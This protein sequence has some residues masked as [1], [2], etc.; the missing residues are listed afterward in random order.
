[1]WQ[2][3][4]SSEGQADGSNQRAPRRGERETDAV[5]GTMVRAASLPDAVSWCQQVPS[6]Y[7]PLDLGIL[8]E[9]FHDDRRGLMLSLFEQIT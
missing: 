6:W 4:C 7:H 1:M 3:R 5:V 8:N 2:R 9:V